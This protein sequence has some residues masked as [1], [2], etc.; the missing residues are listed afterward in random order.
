MCTITQIS[1]YNEVTFHKFFKI[2]KMIFT[3]FQKNNS[4]S[5]FHDNSHR[6]ENECHIQENKTYTK[7][8]YHD[9]QNK[10]HTKKNELHNQKNTLND[11]SKSKYK[12]QANFTKNTSENSEKIDQKITQKVIQKTTEGSKDKYSKESAHN[13]DDQSEKDLKRDKIETKNEGFYAENAALKAK[14]LKKNKNIKLQQNKSL[15]LSNKDNLS[16]N[17]KSKSYKINSIVEIKKQKLS[18]ALQ[19]NI[20]RRQKKAIK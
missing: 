6:K 12:S 10:H 18:L 1:Q 17:K 20:L 8:D 19:K 15:N 16:N 3:G 14:E 5:N 11:N 13:H 7:S 4:H 2:F 9:Q